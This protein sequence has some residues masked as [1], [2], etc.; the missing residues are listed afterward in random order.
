MIVCFMSLVNVVIL[1]RFNV[2][3]EGMKLI[4]VLN[5]LNDVGMMIIINKI[6]GMECMIFIKIE[7]ICIRDLN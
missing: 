2:I 3:I 6:N 1:I 7:S 5:R 4:F